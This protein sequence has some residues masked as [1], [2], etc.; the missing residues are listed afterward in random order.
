MLASDRGVPSARVSG[1]VQPSVKLAWGEFTWM[2]KPG[3]VTVQSG[4][5]NSL[6]AA[7]DAALL[8]KGRDDYADA[9]NGCFHLTHD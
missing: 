5:M 9:F 3:K 6:Y 1:A 2:E 7:A 4:S 8:V